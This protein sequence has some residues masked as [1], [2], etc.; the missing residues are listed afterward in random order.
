MAIRVSFDH[1]YIKYIQNKSTNYYTNQKEEIS[2]LHSKDLIQ[3]HIEFVAELDHKWK[4]KDGNI[5]GSGS[6]LKQF[7]DSLDKANELSSI[8]FMA[9]SYV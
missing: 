5:I 1:E 9:S 4:W 6:S 8:F 7:T 3:E 2:K